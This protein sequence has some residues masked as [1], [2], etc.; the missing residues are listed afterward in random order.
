MIQQETAAIKSKKTQ[1]HQKERGSMF[2]SLQ[3]EHHGNRI[4]ARAKVKGITN[5]NYEVQLR[6]NQV[7]LFL[8]DSKKGIYKE[9]FTIPNLGKAWIVSDFVKNGIL[10]IDI[11]QSLHKWSDKS[12][13][14]RKS[15]ES[16]TSKTVQL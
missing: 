14:Q 1:Q 12:S 3:I 11:V 16:Q 9:Q 2:R 13:N 4:K 15:E 10:H 5:S 7:Q 6:D 8:I